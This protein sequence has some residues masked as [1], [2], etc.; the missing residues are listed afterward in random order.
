MATGLFAW[1]D[2]AKLLTMERI[3]RIKKELPRQLYH[4]CNGL[5]ITWAVFRWGRSVGVV[6]LLLSG[7]GLWFSL[8]YRSREVPY[9]EGL[10]RLL[11]RPEDRESFPGKGAILYGTAVG[12][13]IVVFP[14]LAAAGGVA[15]LAAGDSASTLI[16]IA[17]GRHPI[18]WNPR[19]SFEGSAAFLVAAFI[20]SVLFLPVGYGLAGA[21]VGALIETVPWGI[22]DNITIPLAVATCLSFLL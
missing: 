2:S 15:A 8:R 10:V 16:G 13:T 17:F 20:L 14:K 5:I 7:A 12:L 9:L 22:D 18:P 4:L 21:L 19:L 11:D 3:N 6:L 1:R